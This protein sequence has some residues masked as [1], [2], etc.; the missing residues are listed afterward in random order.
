MQM[1]FIEAVMSAV[2]PGHTVIVALFS[3]VWLQLSVTS[4]L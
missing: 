4:T 1:P 3:T 2:N